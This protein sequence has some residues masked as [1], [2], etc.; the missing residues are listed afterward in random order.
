MGMCKV[1]YATDLR[2]AYTHGVK[3]Y[4][5]GNPSAFDPKQYGAFGIE[6]VKRY[7]VGRMKVI[8]SCGRA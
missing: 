2:I 6:E 4:M 5:A 1:N 3:E 8:G 7:V